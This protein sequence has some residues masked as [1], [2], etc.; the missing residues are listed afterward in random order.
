MLQVPNRQ[1]DI[2]CFPKSESLGIVLLLCFLYTLI[3][4]SKYQI[5]VGFIR[6]SQ[7]KVFKLNIGDFILILVVLTEEEITNLYFHSKM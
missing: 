3:L 2:H 7:G 4:K 1:T 6:S 5:P